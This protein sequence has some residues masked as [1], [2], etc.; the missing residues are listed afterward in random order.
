[1]VN[2]ERQ[3][4]KI[5]SKLYRLQIQQFS[6]PVAH[7]KLKQQRPRYID[8]LVSSMGLAPKVLESTTP[9][10]LVFNSMSV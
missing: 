6:R 1:M 4:Q 9:T 3:S 5:Q 7:P 2:E 10:P 8:L